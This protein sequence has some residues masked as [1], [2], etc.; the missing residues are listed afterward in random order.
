[1]EQILEA[2]TFDLISKLL[3]VEFFTQWH[4]S[5][6][7]YSFTIHLKKISVCYMFVNE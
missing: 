7:D 5:H 4:E 2:H 6:K 3:R 1:M